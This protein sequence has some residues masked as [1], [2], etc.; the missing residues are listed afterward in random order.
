MLATYNRILD[1]V[2]K[3]T[4]IE[5]MDVRLIQRLLDTEEWTYTQKY[6]VKSILNVFLT[7]LL[8]RALL[9]IILR[10]KPSFLEKNKVCSRLKMRKTNTWN[11]K[12][13]KQS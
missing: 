8:T 3:G 10:E 11:Q 7:T 5:N 13:I 12:N 1:K 2:E 9:K 4:K 6:L